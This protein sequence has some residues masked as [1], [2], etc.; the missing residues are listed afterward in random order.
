M[1]KR[2]VL[3]YKVHLVALMMSLARLVHWPSKGPRPSWCFGLTAFE[4]LESLLKR[5]HLVCTRKLEATAQVHASVDLASKHWN[6]LFGLW[7]LIGASQL[8]ATTDAGASTV[9]VIEAL[10]NSLA[11]VRYA[12]ANWKPRVEHKIVIQRSP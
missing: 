9:T 8:E 2:Q 6:I 11:G 3:K 7:R 10:L 1:Y 12:P 5:W 4:V